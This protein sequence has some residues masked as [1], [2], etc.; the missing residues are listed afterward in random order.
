MA[1]SD[2]PTQRRALGPSEPPRP[3]ASVGRVKLWVQ[4]RPQ[5][6]WWMPWLRRSVI[7]LV[8]TVGLGAA[9]G[10]LWLG[11]VLLLRPQL[12]P[13]LVRYL[14]HTAAT[15]NQAEP[16]TQAAIH[17][18]L[19][20]QGREPGDWIDLT[21]W[22]EDPHL[23]GLWL[24][25]VWEVR[26]PCTQAC[27][28]LVTLR[29]YG[30]HRSTPEG[31]EFQ[32][33]D[34]LSIQAPA[35]ATVLSPLARAGVEVPTSLDG[36]ALRDLRPLDQ[37]DL[38]GVWL[39][40]SG[41]WRQGA[42]PVLYGQ[43]VYIDPRLLGLRSLLTWSSPNR[44]WPTW[45]DLDQQGFPE[46]VVNQSVGLE[47]DL[48]AYTLAGGGNS[49]FAQRLVAVDLL[50][51]VLTG[52][53]QANY[54]MA[55]YLAQNGLWSLAQERLVAIK[56]RLGEQWPPQA[57]QQLQLIARHGQIT[58]AQADGNWSQPSQKILALLIDGRWQ[59]ALD[60]LQDPSESLKTALLPLLARDTSGRLWQRV[61]AALRADRRQNAARLWGAL[62]LLAKED[63]AA[64]DRWLA[65]APNGD[66]L[67]T[68]LG[69]IATALTPSQTVVVTERPAAA[70]P[71]T[72]AAR[73][74]L[75][76]GA[77]IPISGI[78]PAAWTPL[79]AQ[80]LTLPQGQRWYQL[81]LQ[82]QWRDQWQPA[83]LPGDT[84]NQWSTLL[85]GAS[86][87]VINPTTG[88]PLA[89]TVQAVQNQGGAVT[90]LAYGDNGGDTG[91]GLAIAGG[92]FHPLDRLGAEILAPTPTG[93]ADPWRATLIR[94]WTSPAATLT[95]P[96]P[97]PP[98]VTV[99]RQDLTG[100]GAADIIVTSPD[101]GTVILTTSGTVLYQGGRDRPLL[102]WVTGSSE[103]L[104]VTAG[105]PYGWLR[106][107]ETA[108][109]FVAQ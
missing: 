72:A 37:P 74:R 45:V 66:Q 39:T 105:S 91:P 51:G 90:L 53:E 1:H 19:A 104:L 13:W 44:Q 87:Q 101:Q 47:P 109:Q 52:P 80:T 95:D 6:T 9:G 100:D 97:L 84:P 3:A 58:Q 103:P 93:D 64:A 96:A 85:N 50:K 41:S 106:W 60:Q 5:E 82:H 25:P 61:N 99:R 40:L 11:L 21:T 94:L 79:E 62:L 73:P 69:A 30:Y 68:Q 56:G 31:D 43:V 55:L 20:A 29:L 36:L 78:T 32:A 107:S 48:Q 38:P 67:Q 108:Q 88:T 86:W 63:R 57:E 17:A 24:L 77:A 70:T 8:W 28:H 54:E 33:I 35:A 22:G 71:S 75:W 59:A 65:Q 7:I 27:R 14:P 89:L 16:Q 15:W 12:P 49:I 4:Q 102:G 34:T 81:Q 83:T 18:E 2:P 23:Q 92:R 98:T 26:S 42:Q 46:L 76:V 10:A